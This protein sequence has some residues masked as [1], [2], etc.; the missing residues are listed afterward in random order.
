[1]IRTSPNLWDHTWGWML[2]GATVWWMLGLTGAVWA[3]EGATDGGAPVPVAQVLERLREHRFHPVDERSFTID[4]EL[5]QHGIADP[6]DPDWRVRLLAVR[7]LVRAGEAGVPAMVEGL[8]DSDVQVR[9]LCAMALG[10][11]RAESVAEALRGV[12]REDPDALARS[13]AVVALGQMESAESLE[14]LRQTAA[15]DASRDVQHQAELAIDQIEKRMGATDA[16]REAYRKLDPATFGRVRAGDAAPD[17]A[18][19][20]TEDKTW[21]LS[22]HRGE[23]VML[24][25]VFADWCPVCHGEFRDLIEMRDEF[26]RANVRVFTLECHDRYRGR[27]M[28]GKE[29]EPTYWFAKQSFQDLYTQKIWWPHLLDRAGAVGARYGVDPLAYAVHAE[30]INRPTTVIVDPRGV[31]RFAYFGTFWGDRPSI[32]QALEMIQTGEFEFEH[33]KRRHAGR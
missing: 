7:D 25:W 16:L 20:D 14:L 27:V 22:D 21:R 19:P 4:R 12:V 1:M 3:G 13:R 26:E 10:I 33:P 6:D 24:I 17:F 5:K 9:Y 11:L 15:Q 31:V 30:Y 32:E 28:V 8:R 29:V 2:T 23:W 18:L